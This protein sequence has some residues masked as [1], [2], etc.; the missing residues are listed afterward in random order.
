M[1]IIHVKFDELIAMAS[2]HDSLE[3]DFQC[4]INDDSSA[5]S[6][7]IPS[8]ED[9]DNLFR[10]MYEEYFEKMSAE[11][12]INSV[13]QQVHNHE[14]SPLT[15]SI[16]IE[17]HEAHPIVTTSKEQTS[18]ISLNKVDELNKE[19]TADFDSNTVF[20]SYD[21]LNF[22][23]AESSTTTID[24]SNMH[25]FHQVQPLIHIWTKAHPLEQVISDPSKPEMTRQP[26]HTDSGMDFKTAFLNGPLKEEVY[27]SQ[28]D[29][30][31]DPDFPD[32]VY[33][34]KKPYTV[35]NKLHKRE[36][37]EKGTVELYFVGT[38][39]QLADQFT[40][41]LPKERFEYLVHSIDMRCMTPT[42]LESLA[43][44]SS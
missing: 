18:P 2:E 36:H 19:D 21:D 33:K 39:Y 5:E 10:P 3:P 41:A 14:D 4:F 25:E 30:F 32:H 43:K 20:V 1:E 15:S 12:S 44:L 9:L 22:E 26:L 38:E 42:Q 27:V 40:K 29:G 34:L 6:M 24:P 35:S 8:K 11:T 13:A 17:E 37:I 7:N 16:I 28:P 31:V 23:K